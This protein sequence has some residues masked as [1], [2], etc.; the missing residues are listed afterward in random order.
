METRYHT[1]LAPTEQSAFGL[2][3][4][5]PLAIADRVRFG[6]LD[7]LQHVNNAVYMQWFEQVRVRYT[8]LWGLSRSYKDGSG[9]RIVIRSGAI[10]YQREMFLDEIY[11]VTCRCTA[12]RRT[13]FSLHQ[14]IWSAGSQRATF[15]CVLVLLNPDGAERWPLPSDLMERFREIDGAHPEN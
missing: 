9:P 5:E 4:P 15:D 3:Q 14:E 7:V 11:A 12:Y 10:H 8:Q 2:V 1:P 6:E 13:S